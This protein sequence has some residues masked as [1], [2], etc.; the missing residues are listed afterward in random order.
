[1]GGKLCRYGWC[2][3]PQ[4]EDR[5]CRENHAP[6]PKG[7]QRQLSA[8]FNVAALEAAAEPSNNSGLVNINLASEEE[9]MTLPGINRQTARNIVEYRRKLGG[10]NK[11]EDLALVSGVGATRLSALRQEITVGRPPRS[12]AV[13]GAGSKVSVNQANVF[14]LMKVKGISQSLAENVVTFRDRKGAFRQLDDLSKVKGMKPVLSAVR[15]FL[16]LEHEAEEEKMSHDF[17]R[18]LSHDL[19]DSIS[20]ERRSWHASSTKMTDLPV[21]DFISLYGP[22]SRRS[23]RG[24]R[25]QADVR[26]RSVLRVASWNLDGCDQ[27]KA[28]NPGVREVVAMTILENG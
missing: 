27:H 22:L 9:L 7:H 4:A 25:K 6:A 17:S 13:E 20:L 1:M 21:E 19:S 3:R 14:Q 15:P 16:C 26:R 5:A 11:A 18:D 23:W 2:I 12:G 10:F 28:D 24:K 8:T